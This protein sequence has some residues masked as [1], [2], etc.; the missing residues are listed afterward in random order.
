MKRL[1]VFLTCIVTLCLHVSLSRAGESMPR[2]EAPDTVVTM[3]QLVQQALQSNPALQASRLR[4][5]GAEAR[6]SQATAWDDPQAG[7]EFYATPVTSANP[8]K[9]G[10]ETD[11]FIQ[12][13]IPLGKKSPM[14][15]AALA[16]VRIVEQRSA[17][18]ERNLVAQVKIAYAMLYAAQHRLDV[19]AENERLLSQIVESARGKYSVGISSQSDVLKAQVEMARL[20]NERSSIEQE[21]HAAEAMMNALRAAPPATPVPRVAEIPIREVPQTLEQLQQKAL[22]N[23]PELAAMQY[24]IEMNRAELTASQR[25]RIPDLM[26]KGTYKQMREGTD[27]WAAMI[28]ITIPIAPWSSGKYSGRSEENEVN[29]RSGELDLADM[30]NMAASDVRDAWTKTQSRLEQVQRYRDVILPQADQ[31][32]QSTLV[33]Y[34]TDKTDFLSLLDS[35]RMIQMLR[36]EYYMLV[37]EYQTAFATLE[38]A[39]GAS[40]E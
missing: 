34:Q 18:I 19:N 1:P 2:A 4:I 17:G 7:V 35:Y 3:A 30:R 37:A 32:L 27:L 10:M 15:D 36:M 24:E 40:L 33:S 8:F 11:Y 16:S 38:K 20:E 29:I 31:T 6:V 28:G 21:L 9:D 14:E 22:E 13:M 39:V 23:R 5:Q 26:L 25:Q 12:Q